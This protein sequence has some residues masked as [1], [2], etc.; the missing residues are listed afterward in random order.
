MCNLS[1]EW[2]CVLNSENACTEMIFEIFYVCVYKFILIDFHYRGYI[3]LLIKR[4]LGNINF[5]REK[6]FHS[7]LLRN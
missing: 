4:S 3:I 2:K 1:F 7:S 5:F 6:K